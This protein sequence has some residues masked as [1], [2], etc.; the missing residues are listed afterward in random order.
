MVYPAYDSRVGYLMLN[1]AHLYCAC[2]KIAYAE[3][4]FDMAK[5]NLKKCYEPNH[6]IMTGSLFRAVGMALLRSTLVLL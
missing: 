3:H 6:P 4:Y 1:I 2:G 5:I